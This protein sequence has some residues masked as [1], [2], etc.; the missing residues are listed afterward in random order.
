MSTIFIEIDN[1]YVANHYPRDM[2]DEEFFQFCMDN[3]NVRIERDKDRNIIIMPPVN[4]DSGNYESEFIGE[5]RNWN[6]KFGN[7][8]TP[9]SSTG[10]SLPNGAV[11]SPD[12]SWVSPERL[13]KMPT[14]EKSKFAA[15]VPD[16][17]VEVRSK[18]DRLNPLKDKMLEWIENGVRLAWLIDPKTE[19]TYI[20]REN[21]S[22]EILEGFDRTL[23]GEDVMEGFEFDM[24][25]LRDE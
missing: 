8:K 21:G 12:A 14:S 7:G 17:I 6:K 24:T 18:S 22:I 15:I 1:N 10:F 11:R 25:M 20:Y 19:M 9:S 5:V 23:T 3:K 4:F 13:S 16:F 2:T